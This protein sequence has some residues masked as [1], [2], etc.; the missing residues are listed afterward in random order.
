MSWTSSSIAALEDRQ[1]V[2]HVGTRHH[3]TVSHQ[4]MPPTLLVD[5]CNNRVHQ[6]YPK[7]F[8]PNCSSKHVTTQSQ[9]TVP[10]QPVQ[11]L[12][13]QLLLLALPHVEPDVLPTAVL[14]AW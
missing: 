14:E 11:P 8:T 4:L 12:P 6:R 10:R 3:A 7:R 9:L 5:R 2:L 1:R 13:Q